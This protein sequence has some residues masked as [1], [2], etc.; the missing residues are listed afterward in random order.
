MRKRKLYHFIFT[1]SLCNTNTGCYKEP[2]PRVL[3]AQSQLRSA[4]HVVR[5]PNDDYQGRSCMEN[6]TEKRKR[7]GQKMSYRCIKEHRHLNTPVKDAW[8]GKPKTRLCRG[9]ILMLVLVFR[10]RKRRSILNGIEKGTP[11]FQYNAF[12]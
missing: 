11:K 3:G 8:E 5:M 2:V 10:S 7:G 12:I 4:D 1:V 9:I 6:L